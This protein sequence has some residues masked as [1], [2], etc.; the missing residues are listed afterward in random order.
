VSIDSNFIKGDVRDD[1]EGII[2]AINDMIRE[3]YG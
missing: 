3:K 1:I 2:A